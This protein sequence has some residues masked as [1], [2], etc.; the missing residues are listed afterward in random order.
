MKIL[1]ADEITYG[2]IERFSRAYYPGL[3]DLTPLE[4]PG[5]AVRAGITAGIV[6][7]VELEGVELMSF[8][9]IEQAS[10]TIADELNRARHG[11]KEADE[12]LS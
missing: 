12:N 6:I 8:R 3:T 4:V 7:G 10:V 9:Q 11:D 5:R 1:A 2:H